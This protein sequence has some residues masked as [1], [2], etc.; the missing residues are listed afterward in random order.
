MKNLR[1]S[2]RVGVFAAEVCR[3]GV[4]LFL[5]LF[6]PGCVEERMEAQ[7]KKDYLTVNHF[8]R[9][10]VNHPAFKG[11]GELMLPWEDNT[12]YFDTRLNQVGSLMPY[13]GHVNAD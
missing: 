10:I 3:V 6:L 4:L 9:D 13:H 12:R 11:F 8:V 1:L 5:T 7:T 2:N